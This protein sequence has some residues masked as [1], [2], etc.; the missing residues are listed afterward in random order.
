MEYFTF[1]H[2]RS[3]KEREKNEEQKNHKQ[4]EIWTA[5]AKKNLKI[6]TM[7]KTQKYCSDRDFT[8]LTV[9]D[10]KVLLSFAKELHVQFELGLHRFKTKVFDTKNDIIVFVDRLDKEKVVG[11]MIFKIIPDKKL[12]S[13]E[14]ICINEA[15]KRNGLGRHLLNQLLKQMENKDVDAILVCSLSESIDFYKKCGYSC[16]QSL[17]SENECKTLLSWYRTCT[18]MSYSFYKTK[19]ALKPSNEFS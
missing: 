1:K 13:L 15:Y 3:S 16:G 9:Y 7:V 5:K 8:K 18:V 6:K 19:R 10:K 17:F 14:Y 4:Q 12:C 2:V 11:G